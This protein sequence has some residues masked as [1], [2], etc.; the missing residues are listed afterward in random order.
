VL[1][2]AALQKAK[3]KLKRHDT[4]KKLRSPKPGVIARPFARLTKLGGRLDMGQHPSLGLN[5][6]LSR[7]VDDRLDKARHVLLD[8]GRR[9]SGRWLCDKRI[10]RAR[11]VK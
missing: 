6:R 4:S 5:Q 8:Q 2:P 9:R 3:T 7:L 11:M 1:V 10:L